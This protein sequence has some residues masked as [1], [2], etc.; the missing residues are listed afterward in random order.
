MAAAVTEVRVVL[1][2]PGGTLSGEAITSRNAASIK[3]MD[4]DQEEQE[5][6]K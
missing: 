1:A 2:S 5:E 6:P 3:V 4:A